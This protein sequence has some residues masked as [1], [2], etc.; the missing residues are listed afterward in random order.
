MKIKWLVVVILCA[1]ACFT[2]AFA[3]NWSEYR[4]QGCRCLVS[5]PKTP[6]YDV[7]DVQSD[8]GLLKMHQFM[9]D[10]GDYAFLLTYTDYPSTLTDTKTDKQILQDV[11]QGSIGDGQLIRETEL[12]IDGFPGKEYIAKKTDFNLK[13][14]VFLVKQRLY[15]LIT[16]YSP[17]QAD[18][19]SSDVEDF[20]RS[21]RLLH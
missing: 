5:V 14:R 1:L 13:G 6:A 8:V 4:P 2:D 18:A 9:M 10:Y 19:L 21:F 17:A 16:V 15:Q 7:K 20:I 12:E 11:V 3:E